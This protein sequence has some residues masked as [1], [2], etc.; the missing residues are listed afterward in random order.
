VADGSRWPAAEA[1]QPIAFGYR[2]PKS[3]LQANKSLRAR[4]AKWYNCCDNFISFAF[5]ASLTVQVKPEKLPGTARGKGRA[6]MGALPFVFPKG[7]LRASLE[8]WKETSPFSFP[9]V[10][11]K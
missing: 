9:L 7:F 8:A 4:A 3:K 2:P 6:A 11:T 5:C 10:Q 1:R